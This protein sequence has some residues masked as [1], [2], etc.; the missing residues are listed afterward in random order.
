MPQ[1][2]PSKTL[3]E[4]AAEVCERAGAGEKARA[5]LAEGMT[6]GAYL[7]TLIAK[8][9]HVDA[10]KVLAHALP[11]RE[12][13]WW[14]CLIAAE[15]IGPQPSPEAA[16]ALESAREWVIDPTDEKRRAAFPAA[17]KAGMGTPV[18]CVAAAAYFSGGSLAPADLPVVAPPDDAT[19]KMVANALILAAVIKEPEKAAQKHAACLRTG[20]EVAE[21]RR[22]WPPSAPERPATASREGGTAHASARRPR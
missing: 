4:P 22:T 19:G 13:V 7:D 21:G 6:V 9:L 15:V 8:G 20:R 17:Q 1:D 5:L 2:E 14:A 10:V 11:K 18:G 12:A 16:A 3:E